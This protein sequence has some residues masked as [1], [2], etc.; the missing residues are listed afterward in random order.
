MSMKHTI[1][2]KKVIVPFFLASALLLCLL[3]FVLFLAMN[4][5]GFHAGRGKRFPPIY[6]KPVMT[7]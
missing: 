3:R 2:S 4:E 1:A 6:E 7:L 5:D